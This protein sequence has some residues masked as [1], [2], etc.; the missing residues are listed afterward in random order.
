MTT[1][2]EALALSVQCSWCGARMWPAAQLELHEARHELK[3]LVY[4]GHLAVVQKMF[5]RM[6]ESAG[7]EW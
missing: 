1:V 3:K 5:R 4:A 2:A 6:R 7:W